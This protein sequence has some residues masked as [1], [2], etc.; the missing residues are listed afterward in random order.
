MRTGVQTLTLADVS[1]GAAP[2]QVHGNA[3]QELAFANVVH[4]SRLVVPGSLFVALAG[5]RD[6]LDFV[7]DAVSRGAS[8]IIGARL[9]PEERW[10]AP[11][12]GRPVAF[13]TVDDSLRAL[14]RLA[15][16][17][18]TRQDVE[19]VGITGSVGKTSTKEV[20]A[21]VLSRRFRVLK[22]EKN[23]NNEIGL[24]LTLLQLDGTYQKAVLEMGMYSL[25][26]IRDLCA[27]AL[28][29]IGVV[30]NVGPV[31]LERLGTIENIARA[32]SELV[33]ALPSSGLA[34]LNGDD[35]RVRA[36]AGLTPAGSILYGFAEDCRVRASEVEPLG[37]AGVRF[38]LRALGRESRVTLPLA[39][40]HNV[41]NALAGV[42]VGLAAGLGWEEVIE[43]LE[44]LRSGLRLVVVPGRGGSTVIDD[45]YNAS[46]ASVLAALDLLAQLPEPRTAILG[47]MLEL[48]SYEVEGHREVGRRAAQVV[49]HLVAVGPRAR[50]IGEAASASGLT[51]VSYAPDSDAVSYVP[52]AGEHI[53]VKGSRSMFMEKVVDKLRAEGTGA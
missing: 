13:V 21:G 3:P 22:N 27:L 14:Q 52:G 26:E 5:E 37:L 35:P 44:S 16:W 10:L 9:L 42:A 12:G 30:T 36:M 45:T 46:P 50:L 2:C 6:G 53:L 48:G 51:E 39:G 15:R 49:Q 20:V 43:G 40:R 38:T 4:D 41:A 24:P 19:V 7:T 1:Q 17:W 32:K 18:R 11:A 29:R 8:G 34:V 33:T 28:P 47:D 23:Y 25:G 31:H